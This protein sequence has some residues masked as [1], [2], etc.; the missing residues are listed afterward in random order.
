M[1]QQSKTKGFFCVHA[2]FRSDKRTEIYSQNVITFNLEKI[3]IFLELQLEVPLVSG[4]ELFPK[5]LH[6]HQRMNAN[7]T[8]T[9]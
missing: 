2:V 4:C 1:F 7:G 5:R 8:S 3:I 6:V 9:K